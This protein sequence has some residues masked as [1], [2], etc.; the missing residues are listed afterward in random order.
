MAGIAG[1]WNHGTGA[2]SALGK[3]NPM[4]NTQ[5]A[6]GSSAGEAST[7]SAND[8]LTLLVTEMKNQDPTANTD[9]NEY[10]NQLV[11]V[12]SLEQ[13]ISINQDLAPLS[14][15]N[16]TGSST[17]SGGIAAPAEGPGASASQ[18][19]AAT[20]SGNLSAPG[21]TNSSSRIANSLETAAQ[22]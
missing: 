7:I 4:D 12:N 17:P 2:L 19:N 3:A 13:L 9:P 6:S 10:I 8:F 5:S 21:S 1:I 16:S 18:N 20:A 15:T 11:Q 22:T 14:S